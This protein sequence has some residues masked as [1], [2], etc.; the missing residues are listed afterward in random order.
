MADNLGNVDGADQCAAEF[1]LPA[2]D[3]TPATA[4]RMVTNAERVAEAP[5]AGSVSFAATIWDHGL[6]QAGDLAA[7]LSTLTTDVSRLFGLLDLRTVLTTVLADRLAL[8][9]AAL[10]VRVLPRSRRPCDHAGLGDL[11]GRL[12]DGRLLPPRRC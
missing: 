10:A 4:S 6:E 7:I 1:G 9:R 2:D 5:D 12:R 11:I 3:H 8:C